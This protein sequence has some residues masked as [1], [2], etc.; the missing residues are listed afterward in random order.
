[1]FKYDEDHRVITGTHKS[2]PGQPGVFL[3]P[4]KKDILKFFKGNLVGYLQVIASSGYGWNHCSV[5]VV[6]LQKNLIKRTPT[7]EEMCAIKDTFW[8]KKDVCVQ[9]HP[10]EE[11]YIN[12]HSFVL[13]IWERI[14]SNYEL[15]KKV[16]V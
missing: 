3:I 13:H 8:D 4:R 7:W 6:D 1:M 14:G 5:C 15:P 16:L 10:D 9:F 11:N 12:T 2:D